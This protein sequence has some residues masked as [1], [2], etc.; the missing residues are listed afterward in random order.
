VKRILAA[1]TSV[2]LIFVSCIDQPPNDQ[3]SSSSGQPTLVEKIDYFRAGIQSGQ[4]ALP[5][6]PGRVE[7]PSLK[8][9]S[10]AAV[11]CDS[12]PTITPAALNLTLAEGECTPI[13]K[14]ACLPGTSIR[15]A[16]IL[17]AVDRTG[18]MG[19]EIAQLQV[20]IQNIADQLNV[21][22]DDPA[23]GVVS[24]MDYPDIYN[25]CGYSNLY[26]DPL[27]DVPYM[28]NQGIDPD[29]NKS[30]LAVSGL[31]LGYGDDGPESYARVLF[32]SYSDPNIG[33]RPG[34]RRILVNF[35]DDRPHDCDIGACLGLALGSTGVDPGRDAV[36]GTADD[37]PILS[38]IAGM[39]ANN[40]TLIHVN[41]EGVFPSLVQDLWDCWASQ[42]PGGVSVQINSDGT[43]PG[44]LDLAQL[45]FD[46][47][48]A[49]A[50]HCDS[51]KLVV[52]PAAFAGWV[53][54]TTPGFYAD[55]DLP[56]VLDFD[57]DLCVPA[58]TAP[59]TYTFQVCVDCD[60][61]I[62]VCEEDTITVIPAETPGFFTGGGQLSGRKPVSYTFGFNAGYHGSAPGPNGE[63]EFNDHDNKK[64][65]HS[66][67]V[68]KFTVDGDC[69]TFSGDCRVDNVDGFTYEV[70]A[71]DH[72][73]PGKDVD[74]FHIQ[75]W[76]AGG[77]LVCSAGGVINGGNIQKHEATG[78]AGAALPT[79]RARVG[80]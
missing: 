25:F 69:C 31:T 39:A 79:G 51:V 77:D 5:P 2:A 52:E 37:L 19:E 54:N 62:E 73:E 1:I 24:Y 44:G 58:G 38:V 64:K 61:G 23:F 68:D 78:P 48:E 17:F 35:G 70:T 43:P 28:L 27:V 53:Q 8:V 30:K 33:W 32:E 71:C 14:Q 9:R 12:V 40:I 56:A 6:L 3:P 74:T 72:G 13:H 29:V 11:A 49:V 46:R 47:I 20:Q 41:S 80:D 10:I 55:L 75:V 4:T 22:V 50:A 76:D 16:D 45:I 57:L 7:A 65:V 59:G 15:R 66:V 21:L 34:A 18:S 63:L 67:S 36:A 42:T 60:G 26:G